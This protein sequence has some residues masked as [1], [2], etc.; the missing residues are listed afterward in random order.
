MIDYTMR[1]IA[2]ELLDKYYKAEKES[3]EKETFDISKY[4]QDLKEEY[5][6]YEKVIA[7]L[8]D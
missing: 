1:D 3:L 4:L 8:G 6:A 7:D 5:H 2:L